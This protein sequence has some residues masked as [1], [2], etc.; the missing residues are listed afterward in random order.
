RRSPSLVSAL[1]SSASLGSMSVLLVHAR[2]HHGACPVV[3]EVAP[4]H[5]QVQ[6]ALRLL[7]PVDLVARVGPQPLADVLGHA[8]GMVTGGEVLGELVLYE[9]V[10]LGHVGGHDVYGHDGSSRGR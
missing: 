9:H 4:S 6:A 7:I 5:Q 2:H 3:A 8:V 1:N 10:Q